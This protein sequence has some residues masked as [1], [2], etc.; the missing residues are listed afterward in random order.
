MQ[1]RIAQWLGGGNKLTQYVQ[2]ELQIW[3]EGALNI[4]KL[5]EMNATF[6]QIFGKL[7]NKFEPF[8]NLLY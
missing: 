4:I 1:G 7:K 6:A 8:E 3:T 2:Q 5:M